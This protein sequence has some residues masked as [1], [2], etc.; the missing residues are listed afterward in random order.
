MKSQ[1]VAT[2]QRW[3]CSV[4]GSETQEN[5]LAHV[6]GATEA[7]FANEGHVVGAWAEAADSAAC[8]SRSSSSLE[9]TALLLPLPLLLLLHSLYIGG[10]LKPSCY[11]SASIT[12]WHS[13]HKSFLVRPLP[14]DSRNLSLGHPWVG[15]APGHRFWRS[16]RA[17]NVSYLA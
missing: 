8:S 2:P 12:F 13:L 10:A 17:L 3:P 11:S 16:S 6:L 7:S 9:Y 4:A 15:S 1:N 14:F 5:V